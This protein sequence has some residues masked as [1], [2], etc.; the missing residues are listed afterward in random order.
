MLKKIKYNLDRK[1][2]S[3]SVKRVLE[4]EELSGAII[5]NKFRYLFLILIASA[6]FL[7]LAG[8][9]DLD[10]RFKG[11]KIYSVGLFIYL[12]ITVIHSFLLKNGNKKR[13][14]IFG[15]ITIL[16][17]FYILTS[18][19][20]S[21]YKLD[22]PDNFNYFLK[23]PTF[24]YYTFPFMLALIQIKLSYSAIGIFTFLCIHFSSIIYG[25]VL[26]VSL[27]PNWKTYLLGDA[28]FMQDLLVARPLV[29]SCLALTVG[30]SIYRTIYMV[31]RIGTIEAEK[32]SLSKYFSPEIVK[33]ITNNP[34]VINKGKRQEVTIL[35]QDI[36]DFTKMS[37]NMSTNDLAE[38]LN[39]FRKRM[40]NVIFNNN[41]T[42]DKYIGDAIMATFGTP[43]VSELDTYNAV[44]AANQMLS[45]LKEWNIERKKVGKLEIRI[46]IGLHCGEVFAGNIGFEDR[47]EYTVIGDAVNT[48][49][50]IESLCKQFQAEFLISDEV[51]Q[52]VKNRIQV[53]KLSP[54]E[55]KG[56]EKAIQIYKVLH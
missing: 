24:L 15:F 40:T 4:E 16:S 25:S 33:E 52:K 37:E 3:A 17:D 14:H 7:N 39:E 41:G 6:G 36:R 22:S 5:A 46:G 34:E 47:M 20:Y 42:L 23:N 35:F 1:L 51:Y 56:K 26:G 10:L 53:E 18:M 30:Y 38:F 9:Q 2:M 44:N 8:I 55:V 32:K 29:Y 45:S 11:F 21:W 31:R 13:I 12:A 48:A 27:A 54:V 19:M 49:S 50:R 28:V 43:T